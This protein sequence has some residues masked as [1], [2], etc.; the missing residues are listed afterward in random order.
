VYSNLVYTISAD[1]YYLQFSSRQTYYDAEE[2]YGLIVF[3]EY[4]NEKT[5]TRREETPVFVKIAL[6]N[7][8]L[9]V[10]LS[11]F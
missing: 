1:Y 4:G 3:D 7:N 5:L 8:L 2:N 11:I 6:F 10:K 9:I